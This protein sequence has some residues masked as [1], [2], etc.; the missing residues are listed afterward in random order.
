MHCIACGLLGSRGVYQLDD[1]DKLEGGHDNKL[2]G[3]SHV[4]THAES[5]HHRSPHRASLEATQADFFH[6]AQFFASRIGESL[7]G[8]LSPA[9][10]G[11]LT[12]QPTTQPRNS[13]PQR[14]LDLQ[15]VSNLPRVFN[16]HSSPLMALQ[17]SGSSSPSHSTINHPS[18]LL[19]RTRNGQRASSAE[20]ISAFTLR[21]SPSAPLSTSLQ[22]TISSPVPFSS[23]SDDRQA[24]SLIRVRLARSSILPPNLTSRSS[25]PVDPVNESALEGLTTPPSSQHRFSPEQQSKFIIKQANKYKNPDLGSSKSAFQYPNRITTE[26]GKQR[27]ASLRPYSDSHYQAFKGQISSIRSAIE[28]ITTTY[29]GKC[30]QVSHDFEPCSPTNVRVSDVL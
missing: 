5:S 24:G 12:A 13:G 2:K 15:P 26:T 3:R 6:E 29:R 7:H 11:Q 16:P 14:G 28:V 27:R 17:D 4:Q 30:T 23:G 10:S 21:P 22:A 19:Q 8:G 9:N 1:E 20:R 25:R 18:G